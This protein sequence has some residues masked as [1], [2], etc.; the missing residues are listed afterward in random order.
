MSDK[1]DPRIRLLERLRI[2]LQ[3]HVYVGDKLE[4]GWKEPLPYYAFKCPIHGIVYDYPHGYDKRLECPICRDELMLSKREDNKKSEDI[5][6][7]P[8]LLFDDQIM[9]VETQ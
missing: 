8:G 6:V 2:Q 7:E 1:L 3:G 4:E 9:N 5:E